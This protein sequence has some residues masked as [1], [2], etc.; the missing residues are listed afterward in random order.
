[1]KIVKFE[2]FNIEGICKVEFQRVENVKRIS[3]PNANWEVDV[4]LKNNIS[5]NEIEFT[6]TLEELKIIQHDDD[7]GIW[8]NVTVRLS[9]P[10]LSPDKSASFAGIEGRKF[11]LILTDQNG[12]KMLVGSLQMPA[13]LNN[14]MT[15]PGKGVNARIINFDALHDL[16]PFYVAEKIVNLGGAFSN[17]F[18]NGFSI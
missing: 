11:I 6:R 14:S 2:K 10:R 4:E 16:E 12:Y 1:M 17:G 13:Y 8:Y 3:A 18:S 9:N 15:N 7:T 5:W